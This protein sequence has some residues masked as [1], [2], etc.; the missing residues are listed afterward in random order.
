M[1]IAVPAERK[2]YI[3]SFIGA[4]MPHYRSDVRLALQRVVAEDG[5]SDVILEVN[6]LWHFN[7][8]V[9]VEQV[10][11]TQLAVNTKLDD[12]ATCRKV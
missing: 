8:A 5:G 12:L 7:N 10:Q 3:A 2:Q 11:G 9:Y 1:Q 6:D 4:Y